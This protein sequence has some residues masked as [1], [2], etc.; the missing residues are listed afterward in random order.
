MGRRDEGRDEPSKTPAVSPDIV[1]CPI[2]KVDFIAS[3]SASRWETTGRRRFH[4]R[5]PHPP[6]R[7]KR[8]Q[9]SGGSPL[10][11]AKRSDSCCSASGFRSR[12]IATRQSGASCARFNHGLIMGPLAFQAYGS[13]ANEQLGGPAQSST[14][15]LPVCV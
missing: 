13:P 10:F 4:S 15:T 8:S 3:L 14:R 6:A 2:D 1:F 7:P 11:P 9:E 5:I 12:R